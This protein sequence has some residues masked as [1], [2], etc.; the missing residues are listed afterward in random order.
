MADAVPGREL[1]LVGRHH[2]PTYA[3]VFRLEEATPG[4]T[5]LRAETRA[6]G[7][8]ALLTGRLPAAAR[9]RAERVR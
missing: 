5:R 3:L 1:V 4:R 7:A 9:R 2:F 6:S 8:H